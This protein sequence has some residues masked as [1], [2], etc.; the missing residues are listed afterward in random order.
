MFEFEK[1]VLLCISL[2]YLLNYV[3]WSI[4]IMRKY[5]NKE[6]EMVRDFYVLKNI[7]IVLFLIIRIFISNIDFDI[8]VILFA[9]TVSI[10]D[11]TVFLTLSY[12]NNVLKDYILHRF[13]FSLGHIGVFCY[14]IINTSL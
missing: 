9:G 10:F 3:E 14:F 7:I 2:T 12:K 8:F 1:I 11:A 13:I 6:F 4:S 5:E